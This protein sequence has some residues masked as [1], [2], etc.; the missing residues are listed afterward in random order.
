MKKLDKE[1]LDVNWVTEPSIVDLIVE[2]AIRHGFDEDLSFPF[3]EYIEDQIDSIV[4]ETL[5][6]D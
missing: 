3:K 2:L 6:K 1:N 5:D 4:E